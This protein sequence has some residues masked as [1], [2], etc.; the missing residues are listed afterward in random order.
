MT[1]TEKLDTYLVENIPELDGYYKE[2]LA[3]WEKKPQS[4]YAVLAWIV[5]PYIKDLYESKNRL[6]LIEIWKQLEH[7]AKDWGD[8]ARNEIFVV[9]TEEIE[10]HKHYSYL[11]ETLKEQ[12]LVYL[13]W[14]PTKRTRTTSINLHIDKAAYRKRWLSEIN[15]IGGFEKLD[16]NNQSE[17]YNNLRVEF[18][19]ETV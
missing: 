7:I 18:A 11:G 9:T 3:E 8:P 14:Y 2:Y 17:I 10:L 1:S 6:K 13:T 19:I 5:K 15:R 16:A 12:W 4:E